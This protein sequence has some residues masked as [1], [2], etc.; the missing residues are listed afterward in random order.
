MSTGKN[1]S[2]GLVERDALNRRAFRQRG[3]ALASFIEADHSADQ[4]FG[5][6]PALAV[7]RKCG[8]PHAAVDR[9]AQLVVGRRGDGASRRVDL[10]PKFANNPVGRPAEGDDGE[11]PAHGARLGTGISGARY[12]HL[13]PI[14]SSGSHFQPLRMSSG[15]H[16]VPCS[17]KGLQRR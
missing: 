16:D 8:N 15:M 9:F 4:R 10:K 14:R 11:S 17:P 3:N 12:S 6:P 13:G 7:G 2:G 5:L 1:P